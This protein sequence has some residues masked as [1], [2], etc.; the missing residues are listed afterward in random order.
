MGSANYQ[1][2]LSPAAER[3]T[4]KLYRRISRQDSERL[5]A[6]IDKLAEEPR[7]RGVRKIERAVTAYRMRVGRYRIVYDV[8]D[9]QKRVVILELTRR[10]EATYN[11]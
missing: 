1:I 9:D 7:P 10:N 2:E 4:R 6:A 5:I 11:L 8:F 3:D